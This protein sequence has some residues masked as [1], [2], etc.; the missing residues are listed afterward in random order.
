MHVPGDPGA[1][2]FGT[3]T[4]IGRNDAPSVMAKL[5]R[6]VGTAEGSTTSRNIVLVGHALANDVQYLKTL[7]F[8]VDDV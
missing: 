2:A 4:F 3:S 1:F 7:R 6:D 8:N 5:F